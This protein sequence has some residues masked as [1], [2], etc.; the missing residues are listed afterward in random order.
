M[1]TMSH[2]SVQ[3]VVNVRAMGRFKRTI[4]QGS[5]RRVEAKSSCSLTVIPSHTCFAWRLAPSP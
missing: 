1:Q 5:L 3:P 4:A 2:L